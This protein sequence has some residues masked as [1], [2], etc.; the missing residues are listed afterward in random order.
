MIALILG[1]KIEQLNN[2]FIMEK[3]NIPIEDKDEIRRLFDKTMVKGK[4]FT[5]HTLRN[6]DTTHI[7]YKIYHLL[8]DPFTFVNAYTKISKNDGALTKGISSDEEITR[9]FGLIEA[10]SIA[11]KFRSNSYK[12]KP[13]RRVWIPKPGKNKKR[14]IDTPTQEDRI[15]QEAIRGILEAIYEP[16]FKEFE[17]DNKLRCT[18]FGF[19]PAKSTFDAC[20]VL[21]M[22][23]QKTNMV[24][25][26][27]IKSA[28][29]SINHDV[30]I[31]I[32]QRRIK[33]KKFINVIRELLCSGVMDDG[34]FEH[35]LC[36]TPQGGIVSPLLFNIYMFEFDK[37]IYNNIFP[38]IETNTKRVRNP[39]HYK[40]GAEMK[41]LRTEIKN[42]DSETRKKLKKIYKAKEQ[43]RFKIPSY[44]VKSLS[45]SCVFT[46]YA[47][48]WVFLFTGNLEEASKIREILSV[49]LETQ[50]KLKLDEDK[51]LITKLT[52]GFNFLG[53][54]LRMGSP[55]DVK[56]M[57]TYQPALQKRTLRRTTSRK[58][59]IYPDKDRILSRMV[60]KGFCRKTDLLPI[61]VRSWSL[62]DEFDTVLKYRQIMVGMFDYY[63][64]CD[65]KRILHRVEYLLRYSCAKTIATR[66]KITMS[67][68]FKRYGISLEV[69]R[70]IKTTKGSKSQTTYFPSVKDIFDA[71]VNKGTLL[72]NPDK[73]H[74]FSKTIKSSETDVDPFRLVNY[75]RTKA[76]VYEECCIC[77]STDRLALHHLNSLKNLSK[78]NL[79]PII[80]IR[81][82]L[83]RK[84]VP[85][86]HGCHMDITH[87]RYNDKAVT[88]FYNEFLARL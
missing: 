27:D 52:N 16:E 7:N 69:I 24:I 48:D 20:T 32:L 41:V 50:L 8:G 59:T 51:T 78:K 25:E 44:Q 35:S 62:F 21:K 46:R 63:S 2:N 33:D 31:N 37:F 88:E 57:K 71:R 28:Y 65:S 36:G 55:E 79:E 74:F 86:C 75:W 38:T 77:G 1:V 4:N 9:F 60:E 67:Q 54:S 64:S 42:A 13:A 66:K 76:K 23:G 84:Q 40:I 15:V 22:H 17:S 80:E 82:Q 12:F 56:I 61:G 73:K 10:E 11:R 81:A 47:D 14:P 5:R 70:T 43:Y 49:F 83:R 72:A 30:L 6:K 18:N 39:E 29:N 68:V 53:F 34:K 87:G 45:K 58:I 85:V 19:R 26:G 3:K